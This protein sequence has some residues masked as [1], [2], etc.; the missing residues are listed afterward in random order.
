MVQR[1]KVKGYD[2]LGEVLKHD[3]EN[4]YRETDDKNK[5]YYYATDY[6]EV[7]K[8]FSGHRQK[9]IKLLKN[10]SK[11]L[12][13]DVVNLIPSSYKYLSLYKDINL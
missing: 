8:L 6:K 4:D 13:F 12:G 5:V 9:Y 2:F 10:I 3:I 1:I 11:E 7:K